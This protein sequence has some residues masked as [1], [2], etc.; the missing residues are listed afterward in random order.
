MGLAVGADRML[1][2]L[3]SRALPGE[4]G[5]THAGTTPTIVESWL[6][7]ARWVSTPPTLALLSMTGSRTFVPRWSVIIHDRS[8]DGTATQD[9]RYPRSSKGLMRVSRT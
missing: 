2:Q 5:L 3:S 4:L 6:R 1:W 8:P 7:D 9:A